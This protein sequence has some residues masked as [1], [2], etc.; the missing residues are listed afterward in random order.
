[1]PVASSS[2]NARLATA[3]HRDAAVAHADLT[4]IDMSLHGH[5]RDIEHQMSTM[6]T[7]GEAFRAFQPWRHGHDAMM[8]LWHEPVRRRRT[9]EPF[10]DILQRSFPPSLRERL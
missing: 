9:A 2:R 1:M 5:V 4:C 10:T 7:L 6:A 3:L 8:R